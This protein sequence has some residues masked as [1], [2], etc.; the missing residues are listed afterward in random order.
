MK[1]KKGY[2]LIELIIF[3]GMFSVLL[4]VFS[5]IFA[6]IIDTRLES[7]STSVV[8]Q[9][10][11]YLLN[12][13]TYDISRASAINTPSSLGSPSPTLDL[14]I[15]SVN[16]L[17]SLQNGDLQLTIAGTSYQLNNADTTIS[18][19]NFLRIGNGDG[20]DTIQ[21]GYTVTSNIQEANGSETKDYQTTVGLR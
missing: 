21:F 1:N 17:Y 7:E 9:D 16:N 8:A 14:T 6:V 4:M 13:L 18:N 11:H 12:R 5:Q 20:R 15:N 3:M 10:G 2:T 19:L